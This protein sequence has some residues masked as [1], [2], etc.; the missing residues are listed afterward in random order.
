M[1][2]S[3]RGAG[4]VAKRELGAYFN[5][6]W[7][8][9]VVGALLLVNGLLFNAY[10]LGAGAQLSTDVIERFFEFSSGVTM[11]AAVLLTIRLFAEE[12]STGTGVLLDGAPISQGS[13]V[14][15]K[16]L[17]ALIFLGL[18]VAFTVYMPIMVM[19]NGKVSFGHVF[20]GYL[21]LL[22]LGSSAVAIGTLGSSLSQNQVV[23]GVT[24]G[25]VLVTLLLMWKLAQVADPPLGG[26][27]SY[28]ALWDSHFRPFMEGRIPS[29]SIV[30]HL[31]LTTA[32]LVVTTHVQAWR[33]SA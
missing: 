17:S 7:G 23:A 11:I 29:E 19:V 27:F 24:S 16:Y 8:Y 26:L 22:L 12:R 32:F 14:L 2:N 33:R 15:G 31:S 4:L 30:F 25:V 28:I 13:V 5:T 20:A 21:G 1:S 9:A 6:V 3:L 10:A 18:M